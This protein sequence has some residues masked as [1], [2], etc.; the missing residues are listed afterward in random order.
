MITMNTGYAMSTAVHHP[1][2]VYGGE[3]KSVDSVSTLNSTE[4]QFGEHFDTSSHSAVIQMMISTFG[5]ARADLFDEVKRVGSGY[6]VTLKDGYKLHVADHEV[7]GTA[8]AS[9]FVG[10]DASTVENANF[11]LAVFVKRK[12]LSSSD[13]RISSSFNAALTTSLQ[14]E[15]ASNLLKGMGMGRFMQQI[16]S[17]QLVGKNSVGVMEAHN[18]GAALIR[19]GVAHRFD[20]QYRPDRP[21]VYVLDKEG[22][23][24]KPVKRDVPVAPVD[25][26]HV[27]TPSTRRGRKPVDILSGFNAAERGFG[28]VVDGSSHACVIKMMMMRFGPDAT[29]MFEKVTPAGDGYDITMKDGFELHFSRQELQ[30]ATTAS[31][32][33]GNNPDA[34]KQAN[35]MLA[36]YTKRKQMTRGDQDPGA[37]FEKVLSNTLKGDTEYRVLKGLGM[38]GFLRIVPPAKMQEQG[39]VGVVSTFG[40][41]SAL[42]LDGLQHSNG[43]KPSIVKSYGYMLAEE[44]PDGVPVGSSTR[45]PP[46]SNVPVGVR[47]G[48]IWR[49]FYQGVEGNCVTVSAIKAAMMK[50]GQSP[51]GI[52]KNIT[53]TRDGYTVT[54]RDSSKVSLTHAELKTAREH[55]NFKGTDAGLLK[56]A[57]FLYAV[58]AKRAQMENHE[59]RAGES[60][61]AAMSTLNDGETPGDALR[62]L[63]LFAFTRSSSVQALADGATGTLANFMHSVVV[64]DGAFDDYGYKHP[65]KSSSWMDEEGTALTLV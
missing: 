20:R 10:G 28:E 14:G 6:D 52:Y 49:G 59:F 62:R 16:P 26:P 42:V 12:Q 4:R 7:H 40:Y 27:D 53:E 50:Y 1:A 46:I 44:V 58:S 43:D 8:S 64:V 33:A 51:R 5:P 31:R 47:P 56:D 63:G 34:V 2:R 32:F 39:A 38:T 48:D 22:Q 57:N 18:F 41:S 23:T 65:L 13:S 11:A 37:S 29:D 60:F 9:R 35:F 19:D 30:Q 45:P 54:M 61:E 24:A 36:A 21:Y 3:N 25:V 17:E 55:S 15:T